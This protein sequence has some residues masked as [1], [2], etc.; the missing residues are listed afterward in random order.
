MT[1]ALEA[2][3]VGRDKSALLTFYTNAMGFTLVETFDLPV[4]T[5]CKLRRDAARLKLFFPAVP[6]DAA[7]P[8]DPWFQP[9]GWRYCALNLET[10]ADVDALADTVRAASGA[11]LLAPTSHRPGARTAVV[12]D[13]EGNAWELLAESA[14]RN[15]AK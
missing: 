1:I 8:A 7:V 13:P 9:G 12:V 15:E 5:I 11:V 2:G 4:G 6:V 14:E 3:L 10:L